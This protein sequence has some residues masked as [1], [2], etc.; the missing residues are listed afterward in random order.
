MSNVNCT[1]FKELETLLPLDIRIPK[2]DQSRLEHRDC[3]FC[4]AGSN[5]TEYKRPD[6]LEVKRCRLCKTHYASPAPN[7]LALDEF[8]S[9]YHAQ[10]FGSSSEIPKEVLSKLKKADPFDDVRIQV[11]SSLLDISKSRILDVGCGKAKFLYQ[12]K[13]L[14][15]S[16]VGLEVDKDAVSFAKEIGI[17]SIHGGN[18]E[19]YNDEQGFD[20]ITLN[21]L[22]EHPLNPYE[23]LRKSTELLNK[24]GFI[25]IWTPN[26]DR[27]N[28]DSDKVTLRVD[29]EHLQYLGSR[30]CKYITQTLPLEIIHYE[31][32]GY[33]SLDG[34]TN[35]TSV[36]TK[37][38]SIFLKSTI[39]RMPGFLLANRIRVSYQQSNKVRLGNYHLFC[40][41]RKIV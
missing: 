26:G 27:I 8:Y 15:A 16:V 32:L 18:I 36:T 28:V 33:P 19:S 6:G 22:I 29:L 17:E 12:L 3:P 7:A 9:S 11:I 23:L 1:S 2:W 31:T 25:L 21:D 35:K 10:H 41:F 38:L 40:I 4:F 20:L 39:K 13:K 30:A 37:K 24:D 34:I 14:G 5:V